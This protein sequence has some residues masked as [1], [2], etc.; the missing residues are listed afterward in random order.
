MT[1]KLAYNHSKIINILDFQIRLYSNSE[2][3]LD[4]ITEQEAHTNNSERKN[5]RDSFDIFI[6]INDHGSYNIT[7]EKP[8]KCSF[9]NASDQLTIKYLNGAVTVDVM[10][11]KKTIVAVVSQSAFEQKSAFE[12]WL[13]TIPVSELLKQYQLYFIHSACLQKQDGAVLFAGKSGQGKTTITL[14]LLQSGWNVLSDDEIFLYYQNG[15]YGHGGQ[16]KAKISYNSWKIF[17]NKLGNIQKFKGKRNIELNDLYPNK[18]VQNSRINAICF[19]HPERE[20]I[21]SK[22]K[23]S[24]VFQELLS[25]AYLNSHPEY[26]RENLD[27]LYRISREI[28]GYKLGFNTN[29]SELNSLLIEKV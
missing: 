28:P 23:Q 5:Y 18:I 22:M 7:S 17:E 29:F 2:K 25:I 8:M 11:K 9:D 4:I 26:S 14:G 3:I 21:I 24:D 12:N 20:N 1:D 6:M 10:Y 13:V 15:L 27:F 16:H 19:I